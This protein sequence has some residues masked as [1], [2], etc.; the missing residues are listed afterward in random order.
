MACVYG[1]AVGVEEGNVAQDGGVNSATKKGRC[2]LTF[3]AGTD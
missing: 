1:E 2:D 3:V